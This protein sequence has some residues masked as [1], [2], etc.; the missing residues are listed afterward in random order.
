MG[1]IGENDIAIGLYLIGTSRLLPRPL[2]AIVQGSSSSGKS[3]IVSA[4]S[5]LIPKDEVILATQITPQALFYMKPGALKHKFVVAG[6]RSRRQDDD[7]AEATRALREMLSEGVLS[8]LVA[9][10]NKGKQTTEHVRQ[11]GPIAYVETTTLAKVFAEDMNRCIMFR[12]DESPKQSRRIMEHTASCRYG[13]HQSERLPSAIIEKH[14]AMQKR[15]EKRVIYVPFA[16]T[17]AMEF[18]TTRTE[19]RRAFSQMLNLIEASALLHQCQRSNDECGR[20]VA[21]IDDY[22]LAMRILSG[23]F[24]SILGQ[25]VGDGAMQL[26]QQIA[27]RGLGASFQASEFYDFNNLSEKT[28]RNYL[29]ELKQAGFVTVTTPAK[30]QNAT[31]WTVQQTDLSRLRTLCLPPVEA[32]CAIQ[33]PPIDGT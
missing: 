13:P 29:D 16:E 24:G 28:I 5:R 17:L 11:E 3:Y 26:M 1:V 21:T 19:S 27:D 31:V 23:P 33:V 32:L 10:K 15:L 7:V 18:P 12:T 6:E 30:G 22:R 20:I 14:Y 4:I 8:K 2:A 9:T 25:V